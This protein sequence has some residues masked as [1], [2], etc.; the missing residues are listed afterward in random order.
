MPDSLKHP[1]VLAVGAFLSAWAA[2]NFELDYRAILW[3]VVSGLFG[4][5]KPY[6]R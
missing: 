3:A 2:T 1:I 4:Y 6:K 5:A